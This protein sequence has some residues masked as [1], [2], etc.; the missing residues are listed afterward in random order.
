VKTP[1]ESAT[2]VALAFEQAMKDVTT[3]SSLSPSMF[4]LEING[5]PALVLRAKW[6]ADAERLCRDWVYSHKQKISTK[7]THGTE[8][9][10]L[11]K[12]RIAHRVERAAYQ[13]EREMAELYDGVEIV[14]LD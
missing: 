12:V 1:F 5:K 14:R 8:L 13:A 9:P 7:G 11:I 4:T 2:S 6:H 10:P 3:S